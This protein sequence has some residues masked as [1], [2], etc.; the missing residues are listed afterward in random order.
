MKK[1]GLVAIGFVAVIVVALFFTNKYLGDI[2]V[3]GVEKVGPDLTQTSVDIGSVGLQLLAGNAAVEKVTIGNPQ[4]FQ[5]PYAF[6]LG[7]VKLDLEPRSLLDEIIVINKIYIDSPALN[8]EQQ[9]KKSNISQIMDNVNKAFAK[10]K[11]QTGQEAPKEEGASKKIIIDD[12]TLLNAKVAVSTALTG[13]K[14]LSVTIN[15]IHLTGIGRKEKGVTA[16]EA[17]SQIINEI[18]ERV[19]AEVTKGL[20]NFGEMSKQLEGKVE[21]AKA[22]AEQMKAQVEQV[23][24]NPEKMVEDIQSGKVKPEEAVKSIKGIFGN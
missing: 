15:K 1:L 19:S 6:N 20:A 22:Q 12:F 10:D 4:G 3:K 2:I 17:A 21:E 11:K 8:F 24:E 9:S 7:E 23:K 5:T 16:A 14:P 18:T 13:G